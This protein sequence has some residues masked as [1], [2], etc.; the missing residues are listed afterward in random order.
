MS[1]TPS[2]TIMDAVRPKLVAATSGGSIGTLKKVLDE[3]QGLPG[4]GTEVAGA[5]KKLQ[6]LQGVLPT[7][8]P[9]NPL[10]PTPVGIPNAF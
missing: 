4:L 2:V 10:L 5:T 8:T 7:R 1:M 3:S 9:A 6:A